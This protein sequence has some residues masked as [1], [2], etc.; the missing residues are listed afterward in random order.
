MLYFGRTKLINARCIDTRLKNLEY[1]LHYFNGSFVEYF[2]QIFGATACCIKT[3]NKAV[4]YDQNPSRIFEL[5]IVQLFSLL[6]HQKNQEYSFII[7]LT[8]H[9]LELSMLTVFASF[10]MKLAQ[11]G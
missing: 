8:T 9:R 5:P 10:G 4:T 6:A 3:H 1:V 7:V 11:S 2:Y